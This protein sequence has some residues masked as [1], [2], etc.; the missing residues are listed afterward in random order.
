MDFAENENI[1]SLTYVTIPHFGS[2]VEVFAMAIFTREENFWVLLRAHHSPPT[3]LLIEIGNPRVWK[4]LP[5][6]TPS[7]K[8]HKIQMQDLR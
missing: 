6:N 3:E 5:H 4:W 7:I 2:L 1:F 8:Q